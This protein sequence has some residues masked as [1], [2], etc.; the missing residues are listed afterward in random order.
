[1]N[2]TTYILRL[3]KPM[4]MPIIFLGLC[5]PLSGQIL[6]SIQCEFGIIDVSDLR[7]NDNGTIDPT[8]DQLE[9]TI[10]NE[11]LSPVDI[12]A[13]TPIGS[14]IT[15]INGNNYTSSLDGVTHTINSGTYRLSMPSSGCAPVT[16]LLVLQNSGVTCSSRVDLN[17]LEGG[18]V[19]PCNGTPIDFSSPICIPGATDLDSDIIQFTATTGNSASFTLSSLPGGTVVDDGMNP[20]TLG[21]GGGS[22]SILPNGTYVISIPS[23]DC[24]P[25]FFVIS[26]DNCANATVGIVNPAPISIPTLSQ[27]GMIILGLALS[28][29]SL[30]TIRKSIRSRNSPVLIP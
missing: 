4:I 29:F 7:C 21:S 5:V 17:Y 11:G 22:V 16:L 1:M 19:Y 8:D 20:T 28:I 25:V 27:W 15:S 26:G 14:T 6:R 13:T 2:L 12:T 9:V 10:I 30:L 23:S 24:E 3:I 18:D